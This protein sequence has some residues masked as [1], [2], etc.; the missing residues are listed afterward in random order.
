MRTSGLARLAVVL[1]LSGA[2]AAPAAAATAAPG[3]AQSG[4]PAAA[5]SQIT[6]TQSDLD[7]LRRRVRA[8]GGDTSPLAH[9]PAGATADLGAQFVPDWQRTLVVLALRHGGDLLSKIVATANP[10]VGAAIKQYSAMLADII[11][12]ADELIKK[13]IVDFLVS[14]G[15]PEEIAAVAAEVLLAVIEGL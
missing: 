11:E 7:D 1:T 8:A 2:L 13:T 6:V 15:V 14:N 4:I 3:T 10:E 9:V 5:S 12:N